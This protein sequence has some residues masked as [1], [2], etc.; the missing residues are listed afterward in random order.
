MFG[1]GCFVQYFR[2][3]F[4]RNSN[5]FLRVLIASSYISIGTLEIQNKS[6]LSTLN[7]ENL[8]VVDRL[9]KKIVASSL[10]I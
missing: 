10:L 4:K 5:K 9:Q 3:D 2:V 6:K 1:A 7:S 8:R